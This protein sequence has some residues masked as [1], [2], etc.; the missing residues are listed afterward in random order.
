[1]VYTFNF[2]YHESLIA[3]VLVVAGFVIVKSIIEI[4]PL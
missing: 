3:F 4:I 2:Y 1:M